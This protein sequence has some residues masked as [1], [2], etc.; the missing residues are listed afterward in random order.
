[1]KHWSRHSANERIKK[2]WP[3]ASRLELSREHEKRASSLY[4]VEARAIKGRYM[5][6]QRRQQFI[7]LNRLYRAGGGAQIVN[8]MLWGSGQLYQRCH[9]AV[10]SKEG[11][12]W[13]HGASGYTHPKVSLHGHAVQGESSQ[14]HKH[15]IPVYINI[16]VFEILLYQDPKDKSWNK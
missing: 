4:K 16:G 3:L 10:S 1:M 8:T 6:I 11:R 2:N 14:K 5:V 15:Q 12:L 9:P 7:P 13:P